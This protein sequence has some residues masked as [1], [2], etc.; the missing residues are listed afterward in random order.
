VKVHR[1]ELLPPSTFH[2]QTTSYY[3]T[4]H[5]FQRNAK[6]NVGHVETESEFRR[7]GA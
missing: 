6:K 4:L 1:I 7:G 3:N 5:Y 2:L